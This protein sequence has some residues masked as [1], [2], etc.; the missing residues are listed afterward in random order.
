MNISEYNIRIS[1]LEEV[2]NEIGK[3]EEAKEDALMVDDADDEQNKLDV[4]QDYEFKVMSESDL[5]SLIFRR[6]IKVA[7][8][9]AYCFTF[10]IMAIITLVLVRLISSMNMKLLTP[11]S[12]DAD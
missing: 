11:Y 5:K 4:V 9:N 2:F 10:L 8:K 7:F 1:T 3:Q 6:S 12:L